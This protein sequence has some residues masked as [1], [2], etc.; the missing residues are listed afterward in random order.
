VIENRYVANIPV[1]R[2]INP[3]TGTNWEGTGVVPDIAVRAPDA[4]DAAVRDVL[5][6]LVDAGNE[7]AEWGLIAYTAAHNPLNLTNGQLREYAGAYTDRELAVEGE[8]LMYRRNGR[9]DWSRLI[10]VDP[11]RF[12][13]DGFDGF[14]MEFERDGAGQITRIVGHYQQGH[15]D[16]SDRE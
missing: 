4:L 15:T 2:A 3:I 10:A 14:R 12:V 6:R 7:S 16:Y 13:I 9:A 1:G 11:D 5:Q 8:R